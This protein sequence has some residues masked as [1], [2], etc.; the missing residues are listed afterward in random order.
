MRIPSLLCIQV[1]MIM[2]GIGV[3]ALYLGAPAHIT[4]AVVGILLIC[5]FL[6]SWKA[7]YEIRRTATII[8]R[9]QHGDF[10]ARVLNITD[11]GQ[12]GKMQK[13]TN[14][15]ID[16]IDA[17]VR[18]ASAVMV[19]MNEG[20][21][22]RRIL[23][24]GMHG[25]LLNGTKVINKAA[26]AFEAAQNDFA[27]R[28]MSLTDTFDTNIGGFIQELG[29]S[30]T[31]L[32]NT[33][34]GLGS[35][36]DYGEEQAKSLI[37]TSTAASG[38][39][40]TVAS[41]SEELSASIREIV[42]QISH[43]S[44]IAQDAVTRAGDANVAIQGLKTSSD[45]IG[46]IVSLIRDIAEQTNLLALNA[47]I[48]AARAGEAGKGFAVVASEVKALA[49]Q[50]A[51]ATEEIEQQ[52]GATQ[53]STQKTVEAIS[54][55]TETIEKMS[56]IATSI[57]AAMEEQ[58]AAM[59]EIVRSTQGAADSTNIVTGVASNVTKSASQTKAAANDLKSATGRIVQRAE[60]L[61]GELEV[62]LSNIKTA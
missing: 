21:Y 10:E 50:T 6:L 5:A 19:C 62:F 58:S 42:S 40:N 44:D 56:E 26:D 51:K 22:F 23:E 29:E 18:E 39:V 53:K 16:Y 45:T 9:L 13:A 35:V 57:A 54:H 20:K 2:V 8:T 47:T 32:S 25:S 1:L 31:G 14:D 36:A 15:M 38:N 41:A 48:E 12:I 49:A 37:D 17:F 24:D 61:R 52:V 3:L 27:C 34:D 46:E 55:V 7:I 28:L 33:S 43:S 4:S 60:N 11:G 30:M 59:D